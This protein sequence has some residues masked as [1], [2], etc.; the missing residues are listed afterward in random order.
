MKK[1]YGILLSLLLIATVLISTSIG[2]NAEEGD[3]KIKVSVIDLELEVTEIGSYT[4]LKEGWVKAIEM[5]EDK[6]TMLENN[7]IFVIVDFYSDWVAKDGDFSDSGTGFYDGAL[8]IPEWANVIINLNGHTLDRNLDEYRYNGEVLCVDHHANLI[9]NGGSSKTDPTIGTITGGFSCN[10]G[11]GIHIHDNGHVELNNISVSGNCTEDDDGAGIALYNDATLM[12]NGGEIS[13]NTT[14]AS[15]GAAVAAFFGFTNNVN[16]GAGVYI[17]DASATFNNVTFTRNMGMEGGDPKNINGDVIAARNSTVSVYNCKIYENSILDE[18]NPYI[19]HIFFFEDSDIIIDNSDI[20]SNGSNSCILFH[21][22]SSTLEVNSCR[23]FSNGAD[24][25]F[26]LLEGTLKMYKSEIYDNQGGVIHA[27]SDEC[28]G[29]IYATTF[30]NNNTAQRKD[31]YDFRFD[32][33][34]DNFKFDVCEFGEATYKNKDY[35]QFYTSDTRARAASI[36]S[37]GSLSTVISII[38]LAV[39]IAA[40]TT[41]LI[42]DKQKK[43]AK[44]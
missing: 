35:A 38:S 32:K 18:K 19:S 31:I 13:N 2:V 44:S 17:K 25:I 6:D 39:A 12:V 11:G 42:N 4:S 26:N 37:S 10:G 43:K 9:V 24:Y 7:Q 41:V 34:Y 33:K 15:T 27:H 20:Y 21:N 28:I 14:Y 23:I 36:F 40:I 5:V 30:R 3:I 22:L 1:L 29:E 16:Y 8:Y